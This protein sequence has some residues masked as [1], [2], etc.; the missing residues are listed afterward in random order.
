MVRRKTCPAKRGKQDVLGG[1]QDERVVGRRGNLDGLAAEWR[2]GY[3]ELDE[4]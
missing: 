3:A 2:A 4:R 1:V